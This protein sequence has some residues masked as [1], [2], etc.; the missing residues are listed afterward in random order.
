MNANKNLEKKRENARAIGVLGV[1]LMSNSLVLF[2]MTLLYY[3]VILIP[4]HPYDRLSPLL[5]I[6]VP[7]LVEVLIFML[8]FLLLLIGLLLS[9]CSFLK[10]GKKRESL[11]ERKDHS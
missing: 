10:R 9:L 6:V 2:L 4:A 5:A 7:L 8:G 1:V 11:S 3:Y